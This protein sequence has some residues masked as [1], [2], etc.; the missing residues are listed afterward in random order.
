MGYR[1]DLHCHTQ[2]CSACSKLPAAEMVQFFK[3]QGL[4]GFCVTDHFTG[5]TTIPDGTP[6]DERIDQFFEGYD[7]ARKAAEG[8]DIAVFPGL[9]YSLLRFGP[10]AMGR[11]T[12]NDFLFFGLSKEWLKAN[13]AAFALK[14]SE[15]FDMVHAA[16][17]TIIHAHPFLEAYWIDHIHLFPRKV[18]A[19]E[20][21]N[22]G[23]SALNVKARWYA[24]AFGLKMVGGTDIH[25]T[26]VKRLGGVETEKK[27]ATVEELMEEI[28]AGRTTIF[29]Q[30]V[31]REEAQAAQ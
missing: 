20:V 31:K 23:G 22:A 26:A 17:G 6:W 4:A 15:L 9:E 10:D 11:C 30:D 16:G 19:V 14:H 1:Y 28:K 21:Y 8:K 25:T 24:E 5:S 27:C 29:S 13:K 3:E 18:D 12:G 7:A 2:E